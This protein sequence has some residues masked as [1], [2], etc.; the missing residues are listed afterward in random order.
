MLR[1]SQAK[2]HRDCKSVHRS[3]GHQTSVLAKT[4]SVLKESEDKLT[5]SAQMIL[6]KPEGQ[7]MVVWR[8]SFYY[9]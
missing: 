9:H 2:K 8:D 1:D 3:D 6:Y 7:D 4:T 5:K